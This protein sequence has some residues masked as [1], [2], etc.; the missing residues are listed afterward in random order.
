MRLPLPGDRYAVIRDVVSHGA[1]KAILRATI[2]AKVDPLTAPEFSTTVV[3]AMVTEWNLAGPDGSTLPITPDGCDQA[4]RELIDAIERQA[5][6]IYGRKPD[7]KDSG[8][9]SPS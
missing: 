3:C 5:L 8:E 2:S 6:A 9:R 7:P 1:D 4:D